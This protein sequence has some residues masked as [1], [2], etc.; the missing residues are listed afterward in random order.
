MMRSRL[1]LEDEAKVVSLCQALIRLP[2]VSG[3]EAAVIE[4]AGKYLRQQ[5]FDEVFTDQYGSLVG[6]INGSRPGPTIL[7]DGHADTVPVEPGTWK[8]DPYGGEIEGRRLYGR[9]AS[10][11]KGAIAAF[12][13]A[14]T[15]YAEACR[16]NF[17]GRLAVALTAYEELF[18]GVAARRISELVRPDFVVIGEATNLA[19]NCG[20][21]GRAE[22]VLEARGRSAHSANPEKGVNAVLLMLK[23]LTG[24]SEL[25]PADDS[26]LGKGIAVVTDI[27]SAPYPGASVVPAFCR[28]TLDRRLVRGESPESVLTAIRHVLERLEADVQVSLARDERIC[29]TG[30]KIAAEKFFPAWYFSPSEPFIRSIVDAFEREQTELRRGIYGFCTNGSHYA[31]ERQIRTVGYGPSHEYLA[32]IADEYIEVDDMCAAVEGYRRIIGTWHDNWETY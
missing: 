21:R 29:Y 8:R 28:A 27:I 3:Q 4:Y 2:S 5:Q 11:M 10:D 31:G 7:F 18:E 30:E 9:G 32:H 22:V 23:A 24:L 25:P 15:A 17:P 26:E 12:L 19:L 1:P 16:G 13:T 14:V 20:Q 6:I